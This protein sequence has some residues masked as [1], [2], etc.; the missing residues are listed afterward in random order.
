MNE[1]VLVDFSQLER[2]VIWHWMDTGVEYIHPAIVDQDDDRYYRE[3]YDWAKDI[4]K[5]PEK[6]VKVLGYDSLSSYLL[7]K[8]EK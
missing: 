1:T 5:S 2:E 4:L 7:D 8:Q 6:M 3:P